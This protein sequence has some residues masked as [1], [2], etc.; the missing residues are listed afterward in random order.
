MMRVEND[1]RSKVET[2]DSSNNVNQYL[3]IKFKQDNNSEKKIRL[4]QK[5]LI[6]I[7]I[8]L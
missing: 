3:N 7:F 5:I 4:L 6:M 1:L 2:I 8:K